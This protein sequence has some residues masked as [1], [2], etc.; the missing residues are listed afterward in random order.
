MLGGS[1]S[2][3]ISFVLDKTPMF[4]VFSK[5]DG[6]SYTHH[7]KPLQVIWNH[8]PQFSTKNT[9][10]VDDLGRNF[11]LNPRQGLKISAFKDAHTPTAMADRELDDL[12]KYL[13]HV[14]SIEDMET[15]N[16][17]DWKRVVRALPPH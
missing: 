14:A 17:K 5:R 1:Q 15:L 3:Q 12:A 4:T 11:A 13:L 9:I 10:H 2:Y 7:V 8:F 6:K 16:H